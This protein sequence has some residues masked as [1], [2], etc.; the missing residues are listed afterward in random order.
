M[1]PEDVYDGVTNIRDDLIDNAK[2][3]KRR[4]SWP[5]A[6]A[7]VLAV[8]LITGS[9]AALAGRRGANPGG[10]TPSGGE[11][12]TLA[13]ARY[14]ERPKYPEMDDLGLDVN[15]EQFDAWREDRRTRQLTQEEWEALTVWE[16]KLVPALLTGAGDENTVC[17]PVSVYLAL[18]MLSEITEGTSRREILDVL[19]A[20]SVEALRAQA[21]RVW[22]ALYNDDGS[23]TLG[24]AASVWLRDDVDYVTAP[25]ERLAESYYAS[26]Y[27]GKMGGG[28]FNGFLQKWLNAHTGGLLED[29]VNGVN[30]DA[31]TAL[32]LAATVLFK[33]KWDAGFNPDRTDTG[34]FHAPAG[35]TECEFM[36]NSSDA[37]YSWSDKF[38]AVTQD[39]ECGG[40]MRLLLPDEGVSVEEILADPAALGFLTGTVDRDAVGS[41]YLKVNL[42]LPKFDVTENGEIG[43]KLKA[44]GVTE[45]FDP[46]KA[47]FS[48]VMGEGITPENNVF[49][50]QVL[51]GA[52][53][54]IDE[55]GCV[56]AAYTVAVMAGTGAPPDD[57]V[58][59]TFDRPFLFTVMNNNVPVFAGIV[60]EP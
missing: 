57:E 7:A 19:G 1:K 11:A 13:E 6:V 39:F 15:E 50:S 38:S 48:P 3:P 20:E 23:Y 12:V 54:S 58:D 45:V 53:V 10:P 44:L 29:A 17:S 41:K 30:L 46:V 34:V 36:H 47:D 8:A 55:E 26:S 40:T 56:G 52:R 5:M 18:G 42:S 21:N 25:L 4:R 28:D 14:P 22:N 37:W 59:I 31:D 43:P 33:D 60:N 2:R 27:R 16:R 49:L 24:L 9:V 35:D 51:H 32:A